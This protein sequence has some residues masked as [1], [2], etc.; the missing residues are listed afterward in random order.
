MQIVPSL[1]NKSKDEFFMQLNKLSTFYSRFQID[2]CDGVFVPNQTIQ[3]DDIFLAMKQWN[4]EALNL[5]FDFHLM[6]KDYEKEIEK[7]ERINKQFKINTVFIH[8]QV[9]SDAMIFQQFR[10]GLV[11]DPQDRVENTIQKY[12]LDKIAAI[13][14][15]SV[16]PGFQGSS[17]LPEM[18]IKIQQLRLSGYKSNIFIDGGINDKTIPVILKQKFQPDVL[19]IGSYLT[20]AKDLE[21]RQQ[22]IKQLWTHDK[23]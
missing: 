7:L 2:I 22:Q 14:I 19:C 21:S 6:V 12:K 16:Y 13:Q 15:M 9:I 17:F 23:S 10:L 20:K 8:N 5:S 18:L 3:I 1:L 4:N 11:L